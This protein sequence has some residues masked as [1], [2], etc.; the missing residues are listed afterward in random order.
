[1]H[2]K[3]IDFRRGKMYTLSV[4][5]FISEAAKSVYPYAVKTRRILHS[6]PEL[7]DE[8]YKTSEFLYGELTSMGYKPVRIHTGM[9]VDVKGSEGK[10]TVALRCD[11]DALPV[12]EKTGLPFASNNGC[13][14]ACGHDAH[15]AMC[16]SVAKVLAGSPPKNNVRLIFQFGEEGAGGAAR[17]IDG[18]AID[19]IDMIFALHLSPDVLKG[20]FSTCAGAMF[21]GVIEFDAEFYGKSSHVAMLDE[22]SDALAAAVAFMGDA[23]SGAAK[24]GSKVRLHVGKVSAGSARNIVADYAKLECTLRFHDKKD[25]IDVLAA[26]EKALTA[27]DAK[28][29]TAGKINILTEYPP[30]INDAAAVEEFLRHADA[31]EAKPAF[32]AEDFA[33]YLQRTRG[34]MAWLGV[35]DGAHTYPLHSDKF[36]FD[37][38][39]MLSGIDVLLKLVRS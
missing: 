22:G 2:G 35:R 37:E 16:L 6:M 33:M 5:D 25:G 31:A 19:D 10:K 24:L 4:G 18:G 38:S 20:N 23:Q 34:C 13:M 7:S 28:F 3:L 9:F 14:H 12:C 27:A 15:T 17:M 39:A 11:F 36:D 30:L 32:T 21:A 26:A 1:M 8:E 29:G